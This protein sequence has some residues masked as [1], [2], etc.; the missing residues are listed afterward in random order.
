MF[1]EHFAEP[2]FHNCVLPLFVEGFLL[3]STISQSYESHLSYHTIPAHVSRKCLT[4]AHCIGI[5]ILVSR[6]LQHE[7]HKYY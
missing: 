7:R 3:P 6:F 1:S 2:D 4:S 5:F